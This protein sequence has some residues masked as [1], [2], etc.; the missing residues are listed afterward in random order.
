ML[1][2]HVAWAVCNVKGRDVE[3]FPF[4]NKRRANKKAQ[5][6]C[7]ETRQTHYVR[8]I[9]VT[10]FDDAEFEPRPKASGD[11]KEGRTL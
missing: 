10:S 11:K 8:Q 3:T 7:E 4:K 6:L 5:E 1:R 2:Q 9:K